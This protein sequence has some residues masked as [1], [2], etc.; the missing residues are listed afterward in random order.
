MGYHD[1]IRAA[2]PLAFW[3][4]D[5]DSAD[6]FGRVPLVCDD[7]TI[8][9]ID[10]ALVVVL[11]ESSHLFRTSGNALE[12][13]CPGPVRRRSA[14]FARLTAS[15][16]DQGYLRGWRAEP[17]SVFASEGGVKLFEIERAAMRF[18]GFLTEAA[19]LNGLSRQA[20]WVARR[21][22]E[23]SIDPGLL[24][25]LVAGGVAAGLTVHETLLKEAWEEAGMSAELLEGVHRTAAIGICRLTEEGLQR[26]II[27]AHDLELPRAFEPQNQDGEVAQVHLE[28]LDQV[29]GEVH[30]GAFTLDA[31]V[32]ALDYLMRI[33][34]PSV[35]AQDRDRFA[36]ICR[37]PN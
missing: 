4:G 36:A 37:R 15:L 19:H 13:I 1:L 18:F 7:C 34:H 33:D 35:S 24:D 8:G 25:N 9:S 32:V 6:A 16:L 30:A 12:I 2:N 10:G 31:A 26:E 22:S 28:S 17:F 14:A 29:A 23:K 11:L 3:P 27:Y 5:E 20:M 21:S